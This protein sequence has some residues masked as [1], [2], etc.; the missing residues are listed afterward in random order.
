MAEDRRYPP[1]L[2]RP[3]RSAIQGHFLAKKYRCTLFLRRPRSHPASLGQILAAISYNTLD[4]EGS[5]RS[6]YA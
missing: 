6:E 3:L 5:P 4:K 1:P 2:H